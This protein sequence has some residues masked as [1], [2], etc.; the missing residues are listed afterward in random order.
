MAVVS[1]ADAGV[2]TG[3][4]S[5]ATQVNLGTMIVTSAQPLA[6]SYVEYRVGESVATT[7]SSMRLMAQSDF[8]DKAFG[9]SIK[10]NWFNRFMGVAILNTSG[11]PI[12]AT[13]NYVGTQGACAGNNYSDVVANI[14]PNRRGTVILG[15]GGT[16]T[17]PSNCVGTAVVSATGSFVATVNESNTA[18]TPT[19]GNVSYMLP[20]ASATTKVAAPTFFDQRD[21]FS[22]GF[23]VQNVGAVA[24][25]ITATFYCKGAAGSNIPFTAVSNA[26]NVNPGSSFLFFRPRTTQAAQFATPF[27]QNNSVCSVLVTSSSQNIVGLMNNIS[28]V[29]GQVDDSKYEA[30]SLIP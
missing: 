28:D 13:L 21:G 19:S 14:A 25:N 7:I 2:P 9:P 20:E 5:N 26:I 30:F 27:A 1:P 4:S 23:Q 24:T 29:A 16:T 11:S 8:D 17:F 6:G 22:S 12:T 3:P 18:G 10:H 15:A